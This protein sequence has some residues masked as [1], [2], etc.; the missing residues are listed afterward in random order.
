[1]DPRLDTEN[2][3]DCQVPLGAVWSPRPVFRNERGT[4]PSFADVVTIHEGG[5]VDYVQRYNG[6]FTSPL[7]LKDFPFD[8][9]TLAASVVMRGTPP[10]DLRFELRDDAG[11]AN[12]LSI[13][14]WRVGDWTVDYV[15]LAVGQ[16]A[17]EIAQVNFNIEVARNRAYY[18]QKIFL[19][20][21]LIVMMS[22]A[23]FWIDPAIMPA[24][25]GHLDVGR[26]DPDRVSVQP[27]VSCCPGS[28]T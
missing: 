8:R 25:I 15:P 21:F 6:L 23:V 4:G 19:P 22:W 2:L 5:A 3:R 12:R 9:Q 1:M 27:R 24:Q 7:D 11:T 13:A 16:G 18:I 17:R 28:P 10:A 20:L 26:A 14:D